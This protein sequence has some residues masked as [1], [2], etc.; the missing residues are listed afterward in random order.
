LSNQIRVRIAP[1]PTG[2]LHVGTARTALYNYL[3]AARENGT[4]ILRL[5]DTDEERSR[6]AYA[7]DIL[8]G[9]HWLGIHWQEGPDIGGPY[10]PYRQT[11]KIDHYMSVAQ[12]LI[13][14]GKAYW[15]YETPEELTALKDEQRLA[16]QTVRYDNRGRSQTAEQIAAYKAEGRKPSL[17]FIIDDNQ[18]V[19]WHDAIRGEITFSAAELGGDMII[20]K[21]NGVAIYNFAVVVDDIDMEIS[22]VIRGEDHISN[23]AK[24]ILLYEALGKDHPI[25]AHVPL[26]QDID[27]HKLSKR[28]H[29]E[30]VHVDSYRKNGYMPEAIVNYLAQ[31]SWTPSDGREIFSL[32]EAGEM[33]DLNKLSKSAAVFDVQRLNW[34]NGHYIRSLPLN[35]VAERSRAFI[36]EDQLKDVSTTQLE[37]IV[38]SVR[39]GLTTLS[40]VRATTSFYFTQNLQIPEDIR[41]SVLGAANAKKVLEK[42]LENVSKMPWGDH[43]GCKAVIDGIGKELSVK[44]KE[45][46]WP[47]RAALSAKTHGP[48][49]G[50]MLSVLGQK[51]VTSRLESALNLC[52][53]A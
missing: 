36:D 28:V 32:Q 33:F 23:T 52:N 53:S 45:L 2:T 1:S 49:L 38:A 21:S 8:D 11:E 19:A 34:F 22:H 4:F 14:G 26:M 48:D 46:Y 42:T 9:L 7:Q 17:R 12:Q 24:Q 5:E 15:A 37:E 20:V 3:Y 16:N 29:G 18:K 30:A 51:Q 25:F 47:V 35:V 43:K 31:M 39:E 27:R 50:T 13:D 41:E 6:E 40:E 44:G 10:P